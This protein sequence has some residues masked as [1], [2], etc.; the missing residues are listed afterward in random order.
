[1]ALHMSGIKMKFAAIACLVAAATLVAACSD[2]TRTVLSVESG[3]TTDDPA[4]G[5][6]NIKSGSEEDFIMS[7]GRRI[8]FTSNSDKLDDVAVETLDLQADWLRRHP[9]W[10]VKL[11]GFADDSNSELANVALSEKRANNA[12]AYLAAKGV[13]PRRMWAK[14]YGTERIVRDCDK[15]ACK[16]LNRRVIVNLRKEF[17]AAA[18]QYRGPE[19]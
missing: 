2:T 7:V 4:E 9:S 11:Q 10:L 17:D 5:F 18:P 14:G 1:M 6:E 19:G 16:A 3:G 8:Y 13:D 12:M 15:I